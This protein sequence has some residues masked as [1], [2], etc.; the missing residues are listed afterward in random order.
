MPRRGLA[1][2]GLGP[3]GPAGATAH[4]NLLQGRSRV[5][6]PLT[7]ALSPLRG[8]GVTEDPLGGSTGR[9][10]FRHR[11]EPYSPNAGKEVGWSRIA[12]R[13]PSPLKGERAGV[14]GEAVRMACPAPENE[15]RPR[16]LCASGH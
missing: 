15:M 12:R 4:F 16:R 1:T 8:E 11:A 2:A 13:A 10:A 5:S 9:A 6:S 7:P 14:R 3:L